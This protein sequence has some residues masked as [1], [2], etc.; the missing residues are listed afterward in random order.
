MVSKDKASGMPLDMP[1]LLDRTDSW[2]D[3]CLCSL[4]MVE[5]VPGREACPG[6]R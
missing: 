5:G 3:F 1:L 4:E 6:R 2:I